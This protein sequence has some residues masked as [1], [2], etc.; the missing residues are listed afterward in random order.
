MKLSLRKRL[1]FSSVV[2]G[3]VGALAFVVG[4]L[5]TRWLTPAPAFAAS[6]NLHMNFSTELS[7]DLHGVSTPVRFSTNRW[8]MRGSQPPSGAAW[9]NATTIVTVGGST[10]QCFFLD[11]ARTWP[12]VMEREL[13][14]SGY[15][16]WVGNAG[17]AGHST[18]GH[19][20]I[21]DEAVAQVRPDYVLFLV[22]VNDLSLS[23]RPKWQWDHEMSDALLGRARSD[24]F[25]WIL[26]HSRLAYQLGLFKKIHFDGTVV[27]AADFS[28]PLPSEPVTGDEF[29]LPDDVDSVLRSLDEFRDNVVHLIQSVR[30]FGSEPVFLT[31]PLLIDDSPKWSS[32]KARSFWMKEQRFELDGASYARLLDRFNQVLIEVCE[33]HDATCFDLAG[34]VPHSTDYYYDMVHFNDAGARLVGEQ[35]AYLMGVHYLASGVMLAEEP[36]AGSN[37]ASR[38]DVGSGLIG[39][40]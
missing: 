10:T 6:L 4:E 33:E 32:V 35:L 21:V 20:R 9:E 22:G 3:I 31:Q 40:G 34:I 14:S 23:L 2:V 28:V 39:G 38:R 24:G 36:S 19:I 1:L 17:E 30:G 26:D 7:P 11:D 15:S 37:A 27:R 18:R 8:G 5:A 12:A 13:R 29:V 25:N 16:V